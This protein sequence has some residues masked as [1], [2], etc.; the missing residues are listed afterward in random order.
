M[1]DT[2]QPEDVAPDVEAQGMKEVMSVGLAAAALAGAAAP[3]K[4]LAADEYERTQIAAV[5]AKELDPS[6]EYSLREYEAAGYRVSLD[7]LAAN[8][9]KASLDELEAAGYKVSP[10]EVEHYSFKQEVETREGTIWTLSLKWRADEEL[11]AALD[12]ID[13]VT[14]YSLTDFAFLGYTIDMSGLEEAGILIDARELDELGFKMSWH[15]SVGFKQMPDSPEIDLKLGVDPD[16]DDAVARWNFENA[17]PS[18]Y[19]GPA[20]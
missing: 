8:G 11:D 18:K 13:Q 1:T 12:G 4:A 7:E 10:E 9:W 15:D 20:L 6:T 14:Q 3:A 2:E 5:E 19:S 16:L 17:W